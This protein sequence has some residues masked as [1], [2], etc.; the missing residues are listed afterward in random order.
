MTKI[1]PLKYEITQIACCVSLTD[2]Q[3]DV[4]SEI[5]NTAPNTR[6]WGFARF[7]ERIRRVGGLNIEYHDHFCF[8]A[9]NEKDA[10]RVTRLLERVVNR[11]LKV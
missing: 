9:R 4:L 2:A 6:A 1:K 10:E 5:E 3:W 7:T 8:D 11:K